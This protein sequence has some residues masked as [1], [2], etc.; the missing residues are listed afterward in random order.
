MDCAASS[1]RVTST[2]TTPSASRSARASATHSARRR[3]TEQ[4]EASLETDDLDV[5]APSR[6]PVVALEQE[7]TM[8]RRHALAVVEPPAV[9]L[10]A[11]RRRHADRRSVVGERA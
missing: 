4:R 1:G 6:Q 5:V 8:A 3:E 2:T 7:A 11:E 9:V 10:V